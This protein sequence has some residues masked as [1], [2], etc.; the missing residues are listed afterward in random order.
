MNHQTDPITLEIIQNALQAISDEMFAVM[1]KTAMSA[2]IYEVLDMGTA[3]TDGE[4]RLA[5]SGAGIPS[6]VGALDKGV[7]AILNYHPVETI[8][9][10]D[11]FATNDP[12]Y[13]G[14]THLNDV[15]LAMPVFAGGRLVAW[16]VNM[17]H[18]N[19]V[20]GMVP[21]SM[22]TQAREVFQ[23]GLR[24][25]AIKLVSAGR[26]LQP[27][28]AILKANSRLPAYLQGDLWAGIAAVRIGE[29]RLQEIL[30]RYGAATF[31]LA[32]HDFME[33]GEQIS[34]RALAHLPQGV[35]TLEEEQDNGS[36]Y[37]VAV[38]ITPDKFTVDLRDNPAQVAGPH[39]VSRDGSVVAVQMVF[40]A[41]T[42][43]E[44]R[45]NAGTFRPLEVLTQPGTVFHMTEPAASGFYFEVRMRLADLL[46]RCL[47]QAMGAVQLP[48]GHFASVCTTVVSG[49][50]PETGRHFTVV[51]PQIGGWG[52]V[53]GR[54][55]NH[56]MFSCFHG[57]TF[58]CPAEVAE[59][60]YGL[61]VDQLALND[62]PGGEGEFQGGKGIV[63]D[64][65]VRSDGTT[66]TCGFSRYRHPVWGQ[67]GGL[68]GTR[69][70]V[71]V[72]R[73]GG[74]REEYAIATGIPLFQGDVIRI[75][76]A[77]GGGYG[78]P[79]ARSPERVQQDLR[80]G[81]LHHHQA[82]EIYRLEEV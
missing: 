22:S 50:H 81:Y 12:F 60:R 57:E 11:V 45:A 64:Y 52:A 67:Q 20:G 74:Q 15:I 56:A 70:R 35:Y 63:L 9:P 43:P 75:R 80:N 32:L 4:G 68:D 3:I 27:V 37:R 7:Q 54:D 69:N 40:K 5:T 72:I 6:F 31:R 47:A 18:W 51:E 1:R 48:A 36:V 24:L 76:T 30:Q 61:Y 29:K 25:P 42:D 55:G 82:R 34:R 73:G 23:E 8:E 14:I 39:N 19:D 78:P 66:L 53:P 2:I 33:L 65:R 28:L 71:E 21:G 10:G 26:P 49:P 44:R 62:E 38:Q 58:N 16:T 13:G 17:A 79:A 59:T 46:W 77:N 41:L